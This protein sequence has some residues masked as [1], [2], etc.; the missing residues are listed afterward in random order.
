M[1]EKD[2]DYGLSPI[3][4]IEIQENE[5]SGCNPVNSQEDDFYDDIFID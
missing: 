3:D 4:I 5:L 2:K 1:E